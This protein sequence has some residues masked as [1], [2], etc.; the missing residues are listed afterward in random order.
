MRIVAGALRGRSLVAPKGHS[1]RPTADRTRQA[2]YNVLEHAPWSRPLAGVKVLDLFAGSGALGMEAVSRGAAFALIVDND[3]DAR[4]AISRNLASLGLGERARV[5]AADATR[6]GQCPADGPFNLAFLDPPYGSD[7]AERTLAR[8]V[9]GKWLAEGAV[10][11][12]ERGPGEA[13]LANP[14]L[15]LLD[16]RRWG[17]AEVCIFRNR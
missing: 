17:K 5:L 7:L 4:S 15:A 13:P 10:I 6:L 3:P 9:K 14:A 1:V 12:V 2:L 11:A 16:Q 8:L